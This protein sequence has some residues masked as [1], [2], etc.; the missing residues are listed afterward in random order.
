V[1]ERLLTTKPGT[2]CKPLSKSIDS[3]R[4]RSVRFLATPAIGMTENRVPSHQ[5]QQLLYTNQFVNQ[6]ENQDANQSN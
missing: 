3:V 6:S 2:L 5:V 4:F 1:I